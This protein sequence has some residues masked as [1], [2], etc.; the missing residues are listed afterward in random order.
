MLYD[1]LARGE[2]GE[3]DSLIYTGPE[4]KREGGG[5]ILSFTRALR[6]NPV[7]KAGSMRC[8]VPEYI[9]GFM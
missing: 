7:A 5:E 6:A 8:I 9:M 4:G 2:G 3:E 1:L